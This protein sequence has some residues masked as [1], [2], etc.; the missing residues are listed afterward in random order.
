MEGFII[1]FL[2]FST[3]IFIIGLYIYTGHDNKVLLCRDHKEKHTK[4]ELKQIG[5]A[6]MISSIIPLIIILIR[7]II[8]GE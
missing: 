2:I 3:C 5:K 4:E 1:L 6:L 8:G 7:I